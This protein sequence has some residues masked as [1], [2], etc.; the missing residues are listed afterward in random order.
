MNTFGLFKK[1]IIEKTPTFFLVKNTLY[2][3]KKYLSLEIVA[4]FLRASS[5]LITIAI[6]YLAIKVIT[7]DEPVE[8]FFSQI[9]LLDFFPFVVKIINFFDN[10]SLFLIFMIST[11]FVQIFQSFMDFLSLTSVGYLKAKIQ[12][13]ITN[14]IHNQLLKFDFPCLSSY[15][16]GNLVDYIQQSYEAIG[17]EVDCYAQMFVSILLGLVYFLALSRISFSLLFIVGFLSL[18]LLAVQYYLLPKIKAGS[19]QLN[20]MKAKVMEQVVED[21]QG[22]RLLHVNSLFEFASENLRKLN[23]EFEVLYQKQGVRLAV[24]RPISTFLPII[25]TALVASL[26]VFVFE[27]EYKDFLPTLLTFL[28]AL[29]RL[30][31]QINQ[32][33][34]LTN[35]LADNSGRLRRLDQ[36]LDNTDKSFRRLGGKTFTKLK[37]NIEITNLTLFYRDNDRAA[38]K[39]I[40]ISISKGSKVALVG[41][42]GAGKS[43][44]VDVIVGLYEP[45]EGKILVDGIN[46][47][48]IDLD[49]WRNSLGVVSQDTILLNRSINE[50][51]SLGIKDVSKKQIEK[52]CKVSQA[53]EFILKLPQGY[54]TII[55]E[56]GY[57]LSGGQR[58][59]LSLA[60]ALLKNPEIL[61]LDEATSSLD[62]IN[63]S[64]VQ[65]AIQKS[66]KN[67]TLITIAH[68]LSTIINSDII[69]VLKN[70]SII[71]KGTHIDLLKQKGKYYELWIK[72]ND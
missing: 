60:R 11:I 10:K 14:K 33:A 16:V 15:K 25:I 37:R 19:R 1:S 12:T 68:R 70:G 41:S 64:L 20:K 18:I 3:N 27:V 54:K 57:K 40:D 21:L 17:I 7:S 39:N 35:T 65:E 6:I 58:Q 46:L 51:L 38:L 50:N 69:F 52:V 66:S 67:L 9:S 4:S 44:L 26:S 36:I 30:N 61:I 23:K 71:E 5:E 28:F 48:H 59:R 2:E 55:G 43:S 22:L 29:Q 47:N 53:H 24:T 8:D 32:I 31:G 13:N 42:S 56:R 63:E 49:S 72:Q 34:F 62:S 45:T